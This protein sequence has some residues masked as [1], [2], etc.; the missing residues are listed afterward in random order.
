[1]NENVKNEI[2]LSLGNQIVDWTDDT[3]RTW[4]T[5]EELDIEQDIIIEFIQNNVDDIFRDFDGI[6]TPTFSYNGWEYY[7]SLL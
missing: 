7:K 6:D 5:A 4:I 2:I 1:M 3:A